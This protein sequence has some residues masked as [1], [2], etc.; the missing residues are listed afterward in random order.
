M[1]ESLAAQGRSMLRRLEAEHARA[2]SEREALP[3]HERV[4]IREVLDWQE[5]VK[6]RIAEKCDDDTQARLTLILEMHREELAS[7]DSDSYTP[8]ITAYH[9]I[10]DLLD[11]L[12]GRSNA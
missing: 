6:T 2:P 7:A 1:F 3:P 12:D 11:E 4:P 8:S 9:R 10:V 5:R